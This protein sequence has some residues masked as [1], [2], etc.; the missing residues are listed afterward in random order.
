ML[1]SYDRTTSHKNP[2]EGFD[3]KYAHVP[4]H[5][6]A[7]SNGYVLEHRIVM[8]NKLGR[9]LRDGEIVHHID[10]NQLNNSVENLQLTDKVSNG[11]HHHG[12]P[13]EAAAVGLLGKPR[14]GPGDKARI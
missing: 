12:S 8:E 14:S 10:G 2:K 11:K 9:M 6:N 1:W 13:L 4:N 3:M 5:P 7:D